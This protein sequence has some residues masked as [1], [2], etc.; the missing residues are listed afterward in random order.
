M[1]GGRAHI[2]EGGL[3]WVTNEATMK[4]GRQNRL[5]R[6]RADHGATCTVERLEGGGGDSRRPIN[7]FRLFRS[8]INPQSRGRFRRVVGECQYHGERGK[9]LKRFE[10]KLGV[11]ERRRS[12][13]CGGVVRAGVNL[14]SSEIDWRWKNED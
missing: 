1:E 2:A 7:K 11:I 13:D 3:A 8:G 12:G 6:V 10:N 4:G 9:L 14:Q 5:C